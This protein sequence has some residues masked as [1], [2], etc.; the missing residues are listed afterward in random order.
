MPGLVYPGAEQYKKETAGKVPA[1]FLKDVLMNLAE[2][3]NAMGLGLA[4]T[5]H[6]TVP[7]NVKTVFTKRVLRA[8][9]SNKWDDLTPFLK[10]TVN[11][12]GLEAAQDMANTPAP[13]LNAYKLAG[14]EQKGFVHLLKLH[15]PLYDAVVKPLLMP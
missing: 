6:P 7:A 9:I 3:E 12:Y 2:P 11:K 4:G 5:I 1:G 14:V 15:G 8:I 13:I 10:A